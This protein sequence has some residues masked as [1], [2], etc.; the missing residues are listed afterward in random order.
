MP[1]R[2]PPEVSAGLGPESEPDLTMRSMPAADITKLREIDLRL[3]RNRPSLPAVRSI[4]REQH[5]QIHSYIVPHELLYI[6]VTG[7]G[8]E[9]S[10]VNKC[11]WRHNNWRRR[12]T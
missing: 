3:K 10:A 2:E 7:F 11:A 5:A 9:D 1:A 4:S 8:R 12:L 6:G